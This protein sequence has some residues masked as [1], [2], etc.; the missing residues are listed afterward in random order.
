MSG[1]ESRAR[2]EFPLYELGLIDTILNIFSPLSSRKSKVGGNA[3]QRARSGAID[4]AVWV[5]GA[6]GNGWLLRGLAERI[7]E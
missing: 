3:S 5:A 1:G 4:R 6:G 2:N 7:T